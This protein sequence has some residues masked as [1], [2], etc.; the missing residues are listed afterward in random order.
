MRYRK[1]HFS[2]LLFICLSVTLTGC[3]SQGVKDTEAITVP[4]RE[5]A[6]FN[7][8][9]SWESSA[10]DFPST[11]YVRS[12]NG[13]KLK[14]VVKDKRIDCLIKECKLHPGSHSIEVDYYWS[15]SH[16]KKERNRSEM[17]E[18]LGFVLGFFSGGGGSVPGY[19]YHDNPCNVTMTFEAQAR[20]NYA[21]N[22]IHTVQRAMP[23][24]FQIVDRESGAVIASAAPAC[25]LIHKTAMPFSNQPLP[26]DQCA[27]HIITGKKQV[28]DQV[29]FY[30]NE[31]HKYDARRRKVYTLFAE[32]GEQ[33]I[34]VV[35]PKYSEMFGDAKNKETINVQCTA[36]EANYIKIDVTGFWTLRPT[37]IALST[38]EAQPLISKFISKS[39]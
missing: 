26:N 2:I 31:S 13:R 21:I 19:S 35:V 37:A 6:S 27:I 34:H 7:G 39:K 12:M 5:W 18:A 4:Q 25:N 17:W 20:R 14:G 9:L 30:L 23:E 24:E 15:T 10:R 1:P 16:T 28:V 22:V 32:P 36:G 8:N 3:Q 33:L 11:F 29:T 38:E